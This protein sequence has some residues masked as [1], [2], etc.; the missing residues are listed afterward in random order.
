MRSLVVVLALGGCVDMDDGS[1]SIVGTSGD[2]ET[3]PGDYVGYRVALPCVDS[4]V[5]VGVIGT[6]AIAITQTDAIAATGQ[7]LAATLRDIPSVWGWGG[8]GLACEPGVGTQLYTSSWQDVDMLIARTGAYLAEHDLSVQV[9][10]S[11]GGVPV[12]H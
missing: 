8:Y 10:I 4:A 11:V 1:S 3:E 9:A 2:V 6:G 7:D 5:N 12:P